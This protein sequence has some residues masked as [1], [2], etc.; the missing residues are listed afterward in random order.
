MI[1]SGALALILSD[2]LPWPVVYLLMGGCLSA[3]LAAALLAPEPPTGSAKPPATLREAVVR[4]FTEFLKRRDWASILA[5]AVLYKLD[6]VIALALSTPF[7]MELGFTR[8][9]IGAVNKG[10][11]M[12]A[13]IVG[14]LA[15]GAY[16]AKAG[17][18]RSLW[19]FGVGQSVSTL[20]F[21]V[22]ARL[23]KS[24]PAMVA[25]IGIEN[26]VSGMGTAAYSAFLMSLCDRRFTATQYALLTSL[27]AVTRVAAGAPTGYVARAFGWEAYFLIAMAAAVPGLLL[28]LRYDRW[29][30]PSPSA[31]GE[32]R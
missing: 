29:T 12:A 20:A 10:L 25:A 2:H 14:T 30:S 26:L 27:M 11:G 23:G 1:V 6:V 24:Y 5:F 7:L 3:G 21:L 22:L 4:P 9:D 18:K 32:S 17:M 15:G 19:L 16:V 8:T 31:V 28:L 13:T